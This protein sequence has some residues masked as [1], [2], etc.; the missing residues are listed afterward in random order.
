MISKVV[1]S[2][3][4]ADSHFGNLSLFC[5]LH[6]HPAYAIMPVGKEIIICLARTKMKPPVLQYRGLLL[7][8]RADK[9]L[10]G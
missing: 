2:D 4:R 7:F 5:I 10:L 3:F 1:F 6:F 9:K 8:F